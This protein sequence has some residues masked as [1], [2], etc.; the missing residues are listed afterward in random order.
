[1]SHTALLGFEQI[2][3]SRWFGMEWQENLT[4][5]CL[6]KKQFPRKYWDKGTKKYSPVG[7]AWKNA[8]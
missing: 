1:M 7:L 6:G 3:D 8:L 5:P 2:G 4:K